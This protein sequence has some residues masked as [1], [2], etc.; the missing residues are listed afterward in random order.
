MLTHTYGFSFPLTIPFYDALPKFFYG[1]FSLIFQVK[2]KNNQPQHAELIYKRIIDELLTEN[3]EEECDH[4]K[5]AV[6]TL[7]LAL[8]VQR[9]GGEP[10][11]TRSVF[12]RFFR[13]V[14][15]RSERCACSAKV[16]IAFA[17]FEM[18]QGNSLK[19]LEIVLK[20]ITLDPTVRPVL[21]WKQFRESMERRRYRQLQ[22]RE[23]RRLIKQRLGP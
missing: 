15:E 11:K 5:L 6:T 13:L 22:S 12:L 8:H 19:S 17:L 23:Q 2:A 10:K 9:S 21:N 14:N 4:A 3:D 16:L 18:K 1:S 7:L 20:A